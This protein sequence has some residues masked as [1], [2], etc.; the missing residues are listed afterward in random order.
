MH[1]ATRLGLRP[2]DANLVIAIVQDAARRASPLGGSASAITGGT[3]AEALAAMRDPDLLDRLA[4]IPAPAA[5]GDKAEPRS[6][7]IAMQLAASMLLGAGLF[8]IAAI[9]LLS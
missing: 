3:G 5:P 2:F 7:G 1:L 6:A 4:L 9:W 8:A